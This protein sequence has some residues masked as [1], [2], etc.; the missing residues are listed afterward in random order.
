M[1]TAGRIL[2]PRRRPGEFTL[3]YNP[4]LEVP[5]SISPNGQVIP[6]NRPLRFCAPCTGGNHKAKHSEI[7]C[8]QTLAKVPHDVVCDCEVAG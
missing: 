6:R 3:D 5:M 8:L 1:S 2:R 7:G 4:F